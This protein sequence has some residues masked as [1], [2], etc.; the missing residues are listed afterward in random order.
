MTF[1]EVPP[2]TTPHAGPILAQAWPVQLVMAWHTFS[3]ELMGEADRLLGD[4]NA[5]R[6]IIEILHPQSGAFIDVALQVA[7]NREATLLN[8]IEA[9]RF[10]SNKA[11]WASQALF[12]TKTELVWIV[13]HAEKQITEAENVANAAAAQGNPL[14]LAALPG[15]IAQMIATAHAD[16]VLRDGEGVNKIGALIAGITGWQAPNQVTPAKAPAGTPPGSP[17]SPP[18]IGSAAGKGVNP[19]DYKTFKDGGLDRPA[20]T[21]DAAKPSI[22]DKAEQA[23]RNPAE[24]TPKESSPNTLLDKPLSPHNSQ[25]SM[26][27]SPASS[28]GGG[29]SGGSP[30]SLAG[31]MMKPMQ[32]MGGGSSAN[33]GS[34]GATS[35]MNPAH[36]TGLGSGTGAG[37]GAG[38]GSGASGL[39]RGVSAASG[40]GAGVAESAARFGTGA[41][42]TTAGA[43]GAVGSQAGQAAGAAAAG[44]AAA[45]AT[46]PL[47]NPTGAPSGGGAPMGVMPT[48]GGGAGTGSA[49]VVSQGPNSVAPS[50]NPNVPQSVPT[51]SAAAGAAAGAVT[52][53]SAAAAAQAV[54]FPV[55]SLRAVGA[56]GEMGDALIGQAAAAGQAVLE[57][58][59]GQT[60]GQGYLNVDWAVAVTWDRS[61]QVGA[62]LASGDGPSFIPLGVR[63]PEEVRV[64]TSDPVVGDQLREA[65]RGGGD[66]V[67]ML[68]R[69]AELR[70]EIAPG[71]RVLA[72]ASSLP[73]S[74][75]ADWAGALGARPVT[76]DPMSVEA[77]AP[78][79]AHRCA[80][81]S[82]WDWRQANAFAAED[83]LRVAS[84]HMLMAC[85]VANFWDVNVGKVQTLFQE[86]KP[87]DAAIWA[88]VRDEYHKAVVNYQLAKA[89]GNGGVE[90]IKAFVKAR[91]A[92]TVLCVQNA[93]T[94]DGCA[95][96]LYASRM[97]GAPL[98]PAAALA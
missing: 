35:G 38:A 77:I 9:L 17:V 91:A 53:V 79:G 62:W 81:A 1:G 89:T 45:G 78:A 25:P 36:A 6:D 92:E 65:F 58:L 63:V 87:I 88:G 47:T 66:P 60:R 31:S 26:P 56:S 95:D 93:A 50:G 27:S 64:S 76:V 20:E 15:V 14:P 90:A 37:T 71:D 49:P 10:A 74:R 75:V 8:R 5:Q 42:S 34:S 94:A 72:L 41:V 98:H 82:A 73:Y 30:S 28:P 51:T 67:E 23:M 2:P 54:A 18:G 24:A 32:S 16:A 96:L 39:A 19:V 70:E 29:S 46:P 57:S 44:A 52:G 85:N 61:G 68:V 22:T 69:H 33:P 86:G 21:K 4:L 3:V 84:R 55:E 59:I 83:R 80:A 97:A 48:G 12:D 13:E 7:K 40:V 43:L 11:L